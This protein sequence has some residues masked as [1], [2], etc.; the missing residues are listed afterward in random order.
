MTLNDETGKFLL[1]FY[2]NSF[3]LGFK[4]DNKFIQR[5]FNWAHNHSVTSGGLHWFYDHG[6]KLAYILIKSRE[7]IIKGFAAQFRSDIIM[8]HEVPPLKDEMNPR[9][10]DYILEYDEEKIEKMALERAEKFFAERV[11]LENFLSRIPFSLAPVYEM[12]VP[13]RNSA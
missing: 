13:N 11:E 4:G 8:G 6:G 5:C 7:D 1:S 3:A 10:L 2:G 9:T 12:S